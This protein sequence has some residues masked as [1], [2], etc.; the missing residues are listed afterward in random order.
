MDSYS[1]VVRFGETDAAG[2]VYFAEL[3]R[4]CHEAY[5]DGL[6]QVGVDVRAFFS[7]SGVAEGD[8]AIAV[9]VVH[10][11]ADFY[12]PMFCGDRITIDLRP[13]QLGADSFEI[14]YDVFSPE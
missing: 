10:A 5:E 13:K 8:Y 4:F 1:R 2:V 11:Q 9:P 6:A 7:G 14:V 3:L 12:R